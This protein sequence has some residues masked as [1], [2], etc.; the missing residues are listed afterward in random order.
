MLKFS[1]AEAVD[2]RDEWKMA[3]LKW[4]N[5]MKVSL[6]RKGKF[7]SH[8]WSHFGLLTNSK[9]GTVYMSEP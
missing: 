1:E 7:P 2:I 8:V 4:N 3:E 9:T 5:D 6:V